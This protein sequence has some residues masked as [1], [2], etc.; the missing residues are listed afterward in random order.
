MP[1]PKPKQK[2]GKLA[3]IRVSG[4]FR[5]VTKRSKYRLEVYNNKDEALAAG[6]S[7]KIAAAVFSDIRPAYCYAEIDTL[8][9]K[10]VTCKKRSLGQETCG[11]KCQL[12]GDGV[13]I[14]EDE[15]LV[16][17]GVVYRCRCSV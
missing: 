6:V 12:Y 2:A 5:F 11:G 9:K 14:D 13:L 17:D 7:E 1:R 4:A 10:I 15:H 16:V 8:T 3:S